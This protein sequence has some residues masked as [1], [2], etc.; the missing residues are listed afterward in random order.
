MEPTSIGLA[1]LGFAIFIIILGVPIAYA[2]LSAALIG[3][4]LLMGLPQA[5]SQLHISLWE[6]GSNNLF[7]NVPLYIFMGHLIYRTGMA[8]KVYES[9]YKWFG[10]FPGGISTTSVLSSASFGALTGSSIATVSTV[11][12]MVIPEMK[13]YDYSP[14]LAM[15]SIAS[16]GSLAILIPPSIPLVFYGIWTETSIAALF[17]AGVAPGILL[18]LLFVFIITIACIVN[19]NLG[20][21]SDPIPLKEKLTSLPKILPAALVF[22]IIFGGIYTGYFSP[23]ESAAVG[24]FSIMV[25]SSFTQSLSFKILWEAVTDTIRISGT[26]MLILAAGVFMSRF[27]VLTDVTPTVVDSIAS[28]QLNPYLLLFFIFLMY[29]VLGAMLDTFGMVILTLPLVFPVVTAAGF[30]SIWFGVFLVLMIEVSLITPPIGINVLLLS[31]L[32]PGEADLRDI[33]I[34]CIPFLL[35]TFALIA[36]ITVYPNIVL[37]LP[38]NAAM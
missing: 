9:I 6:V 16:A 21:K 29:L 35:A 7:I 30:D 20:P 33:F 13:R 27:L 22:G 12:T 32:F 2:L 18:T 34:G 26:I 14:R 37:W 8:A 19:P 25:I 38:T 11:G 28:M 10:R 3:T 24:I 23:T 4:G 5:L 15:G 17:M 31:K 1:L 36:L